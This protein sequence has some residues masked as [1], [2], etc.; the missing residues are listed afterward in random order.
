LIDKRSISRP[1]IPLPPRAC[2]SHMH[3]V[4]PL[5]R[6]PFS[7]VRSLSPPEA[8]LEDYQATAATLGIDRYVIVQPSF[9]GTD[10]ACTLDSVVR[11]QGRARAVVVV[12]DD[13]TGHELQTMHERGARGIRAQMVVK[14]GMSLDAIEAASARIAAFGWH[15]QLYV[16]ARELTD[17]A[18][19]LRRL[20]VP[21]VFDHMALVHADSGTDEPGF[22]TLL[23]LL[24]EGRAWVKLSSA[25]L[26][27]SGDRARRLVEANPERVLWGTDWPHVSHRGA[28]P[29]DGALV[30]ALAQ[31]IPDERIRN[32]VLVDNPDRLYFRAQ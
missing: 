4:G 12:K 5:A 8:T 18:K 16:D 27:P 23:D 6:Y 17:L 21:I 10:N 22:A 29:D 2:D 30:D 7:D 1:R 26:P 13:V 14:G 31:W 24:A 28:P 19:R 25:F 20:P 11:S 9:F 3:I 32:L 15:L